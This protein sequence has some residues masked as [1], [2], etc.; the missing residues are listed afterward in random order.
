MP[1]DYS[2]TTVSFKYFIFLVVRSNGS[3]PCVV[4]CGVKMLLVSVNQYQTCTDGNV[5]QNV[6]N[7][8]VLIL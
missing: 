8:L 3:T 2:R 7:N 4:M 1:D 5:V 6:N